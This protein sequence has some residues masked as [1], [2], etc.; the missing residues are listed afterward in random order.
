[1]N[2]GGLASG[3]LF[4]RYLSDLDK[5]LNTHF[6]ICAGDMIVAHIP[7]ADDLVL[8]AD[9]TDGIHVQLN[10]LFKYCSKNLPS[11][12][13]IKIKCMVIGHHEKLNL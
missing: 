12:N 2:Q 7:W 10:N 3:F 11:V 5:Y 6:G 1:M 8:I 4:R 13:E 9:S